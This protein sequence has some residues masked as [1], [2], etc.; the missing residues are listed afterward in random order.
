MAL[1]ISSWPNIL[2]GIIK[3]QS[4]RQRIATALGITTTTLSRWANAEY[5]PQRSHLIRLIQVVQP[6]HRQEL[7][8]ALEEEYPDITTWLRDSGATADFIAAEFFAQVLNNRTTTTESLLFWRISD[9]VLKQ[10]LE[11]LDPG[12][13]GMAVKLLQCMP[14]S[15]D[16][17]IR[18]LRERVGRGTAPWTADL[19]HDV[20]FL[21]LETMSGY[22]AEVR[23][24]VN[25][26]DLRRSNTFPAY[27]AE[28][29]ISA[30][31]HPVC[32]EGHIAGCLLASS[33]Q[34]GYFSQQR[35]ALLATFSN[36]IALAFNKHDFY[37]PELVELRV[38][39]PPEVQQPIIA[40]FR[41]RARKKF[42]EMT[43]TQPRPGN[44]EVEQL[45]WQEIESELL[46]LQEAASEFYT[47][48]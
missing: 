48:Q 24:V 22:A 1:P 37:L 10:A 45:A 6:L 12:R 14:P 11:Q 34:I 8:D 7:V 30:A 16:G 42:Q 28:F 13:L 29:E 15:S 44:Q 47:L 41:D 19:E 32:L 23:H 26:D 43:P 9:M 4:E 33:T 21:G 2:Q 36:L 5:K 17:K 3:S 40:T 46:R 20:L 18:S 39:P 27:Q 31:A 38:M 25:D 35:L